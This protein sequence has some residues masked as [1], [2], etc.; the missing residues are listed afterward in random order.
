VIALKQG[1][2]RLIRDEN[3]TGVLMICDS[4]LMSRSYGRAFLNSLPD[5]PITSE[6][7][8]VESFLIAAQI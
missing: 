1:I 5:M 4:R 3:D 2:G 8:E 7:A 6:L